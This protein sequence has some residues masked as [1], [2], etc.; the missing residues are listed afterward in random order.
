MPKPQSNKKNPQNLKPNPVFG[1]FSLIKAISDV[2]PSGKKTQ[3]K[4]KGK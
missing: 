4:K 1:S 2:Y 3:T